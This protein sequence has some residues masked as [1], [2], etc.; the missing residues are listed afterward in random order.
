M[1]RLRHLPGVQSVTV[2]DDRPGSGWSDNNILTLDGRELP[3]DDG[4]NML[5]SNEIGPDYFTTLGIPLVE[6]RELT[7]SDIREG[8]AIAIV[9]QT[10]ADRYFK[11]RSALGHTLGDAK[12]L[13]TI[14]GVVRD[15]KFISADEQPN[16]T[17]WF[18]FWHNGVSVDDMDVEVRSAGN[19]MELLPAIHRIVREMDPNVPLQKPMVLSAQ[20]EESYLMPAIFARLA[21][22]FGGLAALL[23]AVGLYGTLA[24]RVNRR[25][26]EIG[27]RMAL[28]APRKQV[29]WMVLRD[30]LVLVIVG[31]AIG[32]PL[33][34][35]G[36][37]LM[38]SMLYNLPA[39][40]LTSLTLAGLGVLAV[41]LAAAYL[42]A[43]RAARLDPMAALRSE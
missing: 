5:R 24:Y 15:S 28:G 40:D 6:G 19:P 26:L 23:V 27:L 7:Q 41:S 16:P 20:F 9:N 34:W 13:V 43:R 12:H 10:L 32:L 3:Y 29:L 31:L 8:H 1:E 33:A 17:A 22:F 36:S 18:G 11:N 38:A 2:A 25:T 35:F 39:H 37:K 21:V 42:P 14:V 30:S 4:R